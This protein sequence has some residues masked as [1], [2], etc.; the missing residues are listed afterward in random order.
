M[1]S[2][3]L[4]ILRG[5][6]EQ[7]VD[8][9]KFMN[10]QPTHHN[11]MS[12]KEL[13]Y[14]QRLQEEL[15]T[16][17]EEQKKWTKLTAKLEK[18]TK[19]TAATVV[20]VTTSAKVFQ[21]ELTKRTNHIANLEA[22]LQDK[23]DR[24]NAQLE[25]LLKDQQT[26]QDMATKAVEIISKTQDEY[27]DKERKL[28]KVSKRYAEARKKCEALEDR[29]EH[30]EIN[31]RGNQ[32]L[33]SHQR[34][35]MQAEWQVEKDH[36]ENY[37]Q[38]VQKLKDE[39]SKYQKEVHNLG[40]KVGLFQD[41][42]KRRTLRAQSVRQKHEEQTVFFT[43]QVAK[44]HQDIQ[45]V[46]N[47]RDDW[48]QKTLK[49]IQES[50]STKVESAKLN[51]KVSLFRQQLQEVETNVQ[52]LQARI[53]AYQDEASERFGSVRK[54]YDDDDD[55]D[56]DDESSS[57]ESSHDDDIDRAASPTSV[58]KAP[59][60]KTSVKKPTNTSVWQPPKAKVNPKPVAFA[61]SYYKP[62]TFGS[63]IYHQT[64]AV[65]PISMPPVRMNH[66]NIKLQ[67]TTNA[68]S[69]NDAATM[70]KTSYSASSPQKHEDSGLTSK[71]AE[72]QRDVQN[73]KRFQQEH[74]TKVEHQLLRLVS[75]VDVLA[76]GS[77]TTT[78]SGVVSSGQLSTL[79]KQIQQDVMRDTG[80]MQLMQQMN[81]QCNMLS[82][83]LESLATELHQRDERYYALE[84]KLQ[85]SET[86]HFK[87]LGNLR[88]EMERQL[89][90]QQQFFTERMNEVVSE[91]QRATMDGSR[92]SLGNSSH[93]SLESLYPMESPKRNVQVTFVDTEGEAGPNV[94]AP[95]L[96]GNVGLSMT[97]GIM[98]NKPLFQG[99]S[100]AVG[101]SSQ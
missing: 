60:V 71:L 56:D 7:L 100:A 64:S 50:E 82:S 68:Y 69:N 20:R 73:Q 54:N 75:K 66:V 37:K 44:F 5:E 96:G 95:T 81:Q 35:Y 77:G 49:L 39:H 18:N 99:L 52:R 72:L 14:Y 26:Q 16:Q 10:M 63:G 43:N 76:E 98:M 46:R 79:K 78:S 74:A 42:H 53:L 36:L 38:L 4:G 97:S 92:R 12:Q 9:P 29:V 32:S 80:M 67:P 61:K 30:L 57:S 47:D 86:Q 22:Q 58:M 91:M 11:D 84:K 93:V 101:K 83:K 94:F 59:V 23:K 27:Y 85:E 51:V 2:V 70:S 62:P 40:G 19:A 6:M 17:L 8:P 1:A 55:D 3:N 34:D 15:E 33:A 65:A 88:S 24:A 90:N 87:E 13:T 45:T 31:L 25:H 41:E 21:D 48:E 89:Q 28:E